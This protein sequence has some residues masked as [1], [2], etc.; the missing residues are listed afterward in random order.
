MVIH[1][2]SKLSALGSE[3]PPNLPGQTMNSYKTDQQGYT[4]K[5]PHSS[6]DN[7]CL[8]SGDNRSRKKAQS[9]VFKQHFK[10]GIPK[11]F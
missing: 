4:T 10:L 8:G 9:P 3:N 2:Y 7:S 11:Y 1:P 5:D 6:S